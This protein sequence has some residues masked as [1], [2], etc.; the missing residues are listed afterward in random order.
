M[1]IFSLTVP[2]SDT[3]R[4]PS[5]VIAVGSAPLAIKALTQLALAAAHAQCK[6]VQPP[7]SVDSKSLPTSMST[8]R[9]YDGPDVR[10]EQA[11]VE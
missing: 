4:C 6:G 8:M 7:E 2:M 11:S 5:G 3:G 1:I 9:T 10:E